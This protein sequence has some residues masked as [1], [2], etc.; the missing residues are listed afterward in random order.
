MYME[1][2]KTTYGKSHSGKQCLGTCYKPNTPYLH[3]ITLH[4]LLHPKNSTCPTYK[5]RNEKTK[6]Y[7][8]YDTCNPDNTSDSTDSISSVLSPVLNFNEDQFLKLHYNIY[9]FGAGVDWLIDN[10]N[11]YHSSVRILECLWRVYGNTTDILTDKFIKYY[12]DFIK[13]YWTKTLY[14]KLNKYVVVSSNKIQFTGKPSDSNSNA[15]HKTEIIN[16]IVQKFVI[17]NNVYAVMRKHIKDGAANWNSIE[18]HNKNIL[19]NFIIYCINNI[20]NLY[21]V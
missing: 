2:H 15:D 11:S 8:L 10:I 21:D 9:T 19:N 14:N 13:L 18:Y 5:W 12:I 3:P 16:F 17:P 6:Q 4:Y 20:K 7:Q 1:Q